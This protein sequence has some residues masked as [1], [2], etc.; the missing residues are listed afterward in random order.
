MTHSED[1]LLSLHFWAT[2]RAFAGRI[3]DAAV[4]FTEKGH[5]GIVPGD[6][7]PGDKIVAVQ[8]AAVPFI[9]GNRRNIGENTNRNSP[10]YL[11]LIGECYVDGLMY[12]DESSLDGQPQDIY[13]V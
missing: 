12:F 2:V 7:R 9:V 11:T 4:C 8:G 1:R 3:P 10:R 13:L 5:A 6:A